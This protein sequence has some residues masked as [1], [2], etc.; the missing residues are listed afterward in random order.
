MT[1]YYFVVMKSLVN[2]ANSSPG[3]NSYRCAPRKPRTEHYRIQQ[4]A[5]QSDE[6]RN[7]AIVERAGE[8]GNKIQ[9]SGGA[10]FQKAATRYLN[11]D[12][13]QRGLWDRRI[14]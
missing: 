11:D 4:I 10:P 3:I 9:L 6:C 2:Q 5:I 12:L 1:A 14:H 7:R 8:G 13:D